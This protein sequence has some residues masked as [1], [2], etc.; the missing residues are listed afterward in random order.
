MFQMSLQP[1]VKSPGEG[2]SIISLKPDSVP[3]SY[4]D[5]REFTTMGVSVSQ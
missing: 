4:S 3:N 1:D 5:F 2:Y